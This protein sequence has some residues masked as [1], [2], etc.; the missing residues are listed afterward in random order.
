MNW[1]TNALSTSPQLQ[2]S[3]EVVLRGKRLQTITT[4]QVKLFLDRTGHKPKSSQEI[5]ILVLLLTS[6]HH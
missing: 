2:K 1:A 5:M 3:V 6:S 4:D